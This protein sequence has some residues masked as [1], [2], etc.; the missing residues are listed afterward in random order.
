MNKLN[1]LVS[2]LLCMCM[3]CAYSPVIANDTTTGAKLESGEISIVPGKNNY[4]VVFGDPIESNKMK[5]YDGQAQG[6]TDSSDPL[7]SEDFEMDGIKGRKVYGANHIYL[8][9]DKSTFDAE[10]DHRFMVLLTY[11]DFGPDVGKYYFDYPTTKGGI[12]RYTITK[13]GIT[14]KW[15]T[16]SFI[17]TD[18]DFSKSL[19][20]GAHIDVVTGAY[21]SFAKIELINIA[22]FENT[23]E[24][25]EIPT[26]NN[27]Q[28][29]VLSIL[30]LYDAQDKDGNHLGLEQTMTRAEVLKAIVK[31]TGHEAEIAKTA[32]STS[33]AD[34][35]G[36]TAK[37]VAVA[38]KYGLVKGS[39]G[40]FN[41]DSLATVR[42]TL[43]F[44]MR[45]ID[46][47]Q[48]DLYEQAYNLATSNSI[49][50]PDDFVIYEDR[51]VIR[52][53]FVAIMYNLLS[54]DNGQQDSDELLI[55]ELMKRNIV[56]KEL[57]HSTGNPALTVYEYYIPQPCPKK[58]IEDPVTGW[59]YWYVNFNGKKMIRPYVT[60]QGWNHDGTKFVFSN[61]ATGGMYEYDVVNE[62][63]RF[64]DFNSQHG[65]YVNAVVTPDDK[66]IYTNGNSETWIMDWKTYKKKFLS[67]TW[68]GT[69]ATT[70]DGKWISGYG[71]ASNMLYRTNTETGE[72]ETLGI[73]T[74]ILERWKTYPV[75]SG[76]GHPMI[77][78][79]YPE[80]YF[81][82]HEGTTTGIPDRLM[83]GRFDT[84][85]VYNM[86]VQAGPQDSPDTRETSGHEVWSMDGTT[87]YWVKY[88]HASNLGQSGL[89]RTD[90]YGK[91][92]EYINGD[93]SW[94]HCYPS[95]DHNWVAGDT[96]QGQIGIVNTNTYESFYIAKFRMF[97][98]VHPYQPHPH[99]NYGNTMVSWQMVDENNML[100]V[101]FADIS[102]LTAD[103]RKNERLP[104]DDKITLIINEN[105]DYMANET[106]FDGERCFE[107]K[108][109]NKIFIDVNDDY[110]FEENANLKLE[111]TYL[112]YGKQPI[113]LKYTQLDVNDRMQ[114]ANRE[115][116]I[117]NSPE[118]ADVKQW[119]TAVFDVE[120]MSLTNRGQ[121][122]SD[123]ML[124][125]P[126]SQ[127][128][129]K[130]I[131]IVEE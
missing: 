97:S 119:K 101:G 126:L 71:G 80:L 11:Y 56:T 118:K 96:N 111:I 77:N 38:E 112:D 121:H 107:V 66:I 89:M 29:E 41:P 61:D 79:V 28:A 42:E 53:N 74:D 70:N 3:L 6:I 93:F 122:Q 68:Y 86:F 20:N 31:A 26:V 17:I 13:P 120:N 24:S 109:N 10:N 92:R 72:T 35:S 115:N 43:T 37:V 91:T 98:Q 90:K 18:A 83:L 40:R 75:S 104:L 5:Y 45:Y 51:P 21:N 27:I 48:P 60:Q 15:S 44:A 99:I 57:I 14:P 131:K 125:S 105:A 62:T 52:D 55:V 49:V 94:W 30:G 95:S 103:P 36:E 25:L 34:V 69:M 117:V 63:V 16:E 65:S 58:L 32:P 113:Q 47:T 123:F 7:W 59:K 67:S 129:I 127:M 76:K 128:L 8:E 23:G 81:F 78:P 108:Q 84:G 106:E 114:L 102:H 22:D 19:A 4:Y 116:V 130:D 124:Y 88:Y 85:E 39:Y 100:G 46:Y 33:F 87:M 2:I 12:N 82:C 9:L 50:M 110:K 73:P 64:L 54:A 1:K